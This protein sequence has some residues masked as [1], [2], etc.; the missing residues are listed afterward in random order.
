MPNTNYADLVI[1]TYQWNKTTAT[2]IPTTL[3]LGVSSSTPTQGPTGGANALLTNCNVT[4]PAIGTNG[5]TRLAVTVNSTNF[6]LT[7]SQPSSGCQFQ[8]GVTFTLGPSTTG[9][10]ASSAV[11]TYWFLADLSSAGNLWSFGANS[12]TQQVT[13]AG[14]VINYTAGSLTFL[15]N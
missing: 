13:G 6:V 3:Y 2:P 4:E 14:Q 11:F 1:A 9:A 8:N 5:Y 12:P 10:W 15:T 7:G